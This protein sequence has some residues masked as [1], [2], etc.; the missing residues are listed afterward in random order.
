M[1]LPVLIAPSILSADFSKLGQEVRD[2]VAA[3]ADWVHLD[4]M[5]GHFVPNITFGPPV[6]AALR[7]HPTNVRLPSDDRAL[8][9][10]SRGLRQG[11]LRRH[12][13]PRRGDRHLDRSLQAIRALGKKAGVVAQSRRRRPRRSNMSSTVSISCC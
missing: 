7:P 3:G 6:V 5:D 12:H 8:R 9:S 2:I 10:L 1:T 13:R 11:R 4:V